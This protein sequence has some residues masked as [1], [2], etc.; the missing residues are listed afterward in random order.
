MFDED[1]KATP[2]QK[3]LDLETL[4]VGELNERIAALK[5]E[6]ERCEQAIKKK[7]AG[8]DAANALFSKPSN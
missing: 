6:I 8:L 1:F 3:P 4:S 2:N 5:S 7:S